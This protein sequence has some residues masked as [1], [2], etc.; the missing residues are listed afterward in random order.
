MP[1]TISGRHRAPSTSSFPRLARRLA[2]IGTAAVAAGVAVAGPA[3]AASDATWNS[4]AQCES[5]GDWS[6]NTGNGYYGGLQ[7]SQ[8]TWEAYGGLQYAPRADLA[9]R[10]QQI[11]VAERTQDS[12]GWG[13]WPACSAKL[14]LTGSDN[15]GSA[16]A[17]APSAPA[18]SSS[19]PSASKPSSSSTP[20]AHHHHSTPAP[21]PTAGTYTV[22]AGDTLSEIAQQLGLSGW[23]ELYAVNTATVADPDLIFVGQVLQIPA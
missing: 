14:G 15:A 17:P 9:T 7:F 18:P 16:A 22:V 19:K 23:D 10:E 11:A 13:A 5:S 21:A 8:P 6:I 20:R 12:Q 2:V 3:A 4:L 1:S